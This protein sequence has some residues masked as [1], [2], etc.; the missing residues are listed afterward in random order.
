MKQDL[1]QIQFNMHRQRCFRASFRQG[2]FRGFFEA[3]TQL[4]DVILATIVQTLSYMY[5][6]IY[7]ITYYIYCI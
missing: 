4:C 5:M 1:N 7:N 2:G 6:Y 3:E